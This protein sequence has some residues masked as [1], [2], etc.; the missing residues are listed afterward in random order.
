MPD[1]MKVKLKVKRFDPA[2][3]GGKTWLQ[4]YEVDIH[5]DSTVLDALIQVREHEDGHLI[6]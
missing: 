2:E 5:P 4:E 3:A 6:I 1:T